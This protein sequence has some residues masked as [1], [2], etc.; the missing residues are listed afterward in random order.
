MPGEK[1]FYQT[2]RGKLLLWFLGLTLLPLLALSLFSYEISSK[3]LKEQV[4]LNLR[5]V[6]DMKAQ[7]IE[8][9]FSEIGEDLEVLA[10]TPL[11]MKT[12]DDLEA[13]VAAYGGSPAAFIESPGYKALYEKADRH[14]RRYEDIYGYSDLLLIDHAG[15]ILYTLA[16]KADLGT[17]ILK[18]RYSDTN[19]GRLV[20]AVNDTQ[21]EQIADFAPYGP[22]GNAPEAFVGRT[23]YDEKGERLGVIVLRLSIEE[24][25][26]IMR[27]NV[28]MGDTGET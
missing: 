7:E 27:K 24:I 8:G 19:L 21:R 18:G 12:L 26:G 14:L 4:L 9:Y 13:S 25:D 10:G 15:N 3:S 6:N 20:K 22:S 1:R 2:I 11:L 17:N 16:R 5:V 28:G 23:V